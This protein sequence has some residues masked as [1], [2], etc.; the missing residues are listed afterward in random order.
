MLRHLIKCGRVGT[1]SRILFPLRSW[2]TRAWFRLTKLLVWTVIVVDIWV[3]VQVT[4]VTRVWLCSLTG[5]EGLKS[6]KSSCTRRVLS[7]GAP[8]FP[9]CIPLAEILWVGPKLSELALITQVNR[10]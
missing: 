9:I 3:R 1:L 10:P 7:V 5:W 6:L 2:T 8:F 4:M